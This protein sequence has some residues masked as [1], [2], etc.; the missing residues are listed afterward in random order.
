M[1]VFILGGLLGVA[2]AH[3]RLRNTGMVIR[4]GRGA[5]SDG[6]FSVSGPCGGVNTFGSNG[7]G[8]AQVTSGDTVCAKIAYNGGHQSANNAFHAA[9]KCGSTSQNDFK[10]PAN[11]LPLVAGPNASPIAPATGALPSRV[12]ATDSDRNGYTLC[13]SVP[14]SAPAQAQCTLSLLDQRDWGGCIDMRIRA[15][16]PPP[17]PPPTPHPPIVFK[18]TVYKVTGGCGECTYDCCPVGHIAV[19]ANGNAAVTFSLSEQGQ[20]A[21]SNCDVAKFNAANTAIATTLATEADGVTAS[22]TFLATLPDGETQ[23]MTVSIRGEAVEFVNTGTRAP[24]VCD[25][26]TTVLPGVTLD[27]AV[28]QR[29]VGAAAVIAAGGE[30]K[31]VG[32]GGGGDGG[33]DG[34]GGGGGGGGGAAA[35]I[36][37][38]CIGAVGAAAFVARKRKMDSLSWMNGASGAA[39]QLPGPFV[40][41]G[42]ASGA[43]PALPPKPLPKPSALRPTGPPPTAPPRPPPRPSRMSQNPEACD[44]SMNLKASEAGTI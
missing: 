42:A 16:P 24:R 5:T 44:S 15:T 43:P 26:T 18:E 27:S 9:W 4:N 29:L 13:V 36:A 14:A 35:A 41:S 25:G 12:I 10:N 38:V 32:D 8:T 11:D 23:E 3:V 6:S 34:G 20:G 2:D 22:G 30:A 19:L 37:I 21:G 7:G 28:Q 39:P 40:P 33:G 17:T 1:K 31:V